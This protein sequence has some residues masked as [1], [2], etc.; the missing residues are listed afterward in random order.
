[1]GHLAEESD[2]RS[3]ADGCSQ[4]LQP[5]LIVSRAGDPE[6]RSGNPLQDSRPSRDEL[7]VPLVAFVRRLS[8][9][10]QH[11]GRS[12]GRDVAY[13]PVGTG[14]DPRVV[15]LRAQVNDRRG[16][17]KRRI[18]GSISSLE[19]FEMLRS[20]SARRR[21]ARPNSRAAAPRSRRAR[22]RGAE[23]SENDNRPTPTYTNITRSNALCSRGTN[24][25]SASGFPRSHTSRAARREPTEIT[26]LHPVPLPRVE[27]AP[28]GE[29]RDPARRGE[30]AEDASRR[31]P[32]RPAVRTVVVDAEFGTDDEDAAGAWHRRVLEAVG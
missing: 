27:Q 18:V 21:D 26:G 11:R 17:G 25:S 10:D 5:R 7:I 30:R 4:R 29:P 9:N 23:R 6:L 31:W 32:G 3:D 8:R 19:N 16:S 24:G 20:G 14:V 2:A 15:R 13:R 1:M 12:G 22:G 28:S